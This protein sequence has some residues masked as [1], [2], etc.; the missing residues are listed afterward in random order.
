MGTITVRKY[1]ANSGL[2]VT[3][4]GI[5]AFNLLLKGVDKINISLITDQKI[6]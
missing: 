3:V 2:S 6:Q 1:S 4:H 5:F